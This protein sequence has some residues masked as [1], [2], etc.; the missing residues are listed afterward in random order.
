[1]T[2]QW[3]RLKAAP[4]TREARTSRHIHEIFPA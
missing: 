4:L 3:S 1:V 2:P